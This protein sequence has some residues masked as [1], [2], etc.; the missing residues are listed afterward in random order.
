MLETEKSGR[1]R[2]QE[3]ITGRTI[4]VKPYEFK[5]REVLFFCLF[6]SG[7]RGNAVFVSTLVHSLDA[8]LGLGV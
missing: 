8:R 1:R 5:K 3:A 7:Q 2:L 6:L 4:S